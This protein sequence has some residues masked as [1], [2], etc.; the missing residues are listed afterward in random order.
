M[1]TKENNTD[2]E[3]IVISRD[4]WNIIVSQSV[5]LERRDKRISKMIDE[6]KCEKVNSI[7]ETKSK[8]LC[9]VVLFVP[10]NLKR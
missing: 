7:Q 10:K 3:T 5:M 2:K 6:L 1:A 4:V 8:P 9:K